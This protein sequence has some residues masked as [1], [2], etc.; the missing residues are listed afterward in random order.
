MR[1]TSVASEAGGSEASGKQTATTVAPPHETV[2]NRERFTPHQLIPITA[3]AVTTCRV[4][5]ENRM[6]VISA[7]RA[8]LSANASA[9]WDRIA[10]SPLSYSR[11]LYR[12]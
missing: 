1:G 7:T 5:Q 9:S 11:L 2:D 8:L 12:G 3:I 10:A 4:R 6:P